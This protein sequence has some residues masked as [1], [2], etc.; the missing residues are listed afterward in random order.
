MQ[1]RN[2][3]EVVV[4]YNLTYVFQGKKKKK[5]KKHFYYEKLCFWMSMYCFS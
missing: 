3:M 4:S 1:L 5:E 2:K